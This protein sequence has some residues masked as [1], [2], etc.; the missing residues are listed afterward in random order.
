MRNGSHH[1]KIEFCLEITAFAPVV[2]L[3]VH[4]RLMGE[5][6]LLRCENPR[7]AGALTLSEWPNPVSAYGSNACAP[8]PVMTVG[9]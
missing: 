4:F 5:S 3:S 2:S 6:K 8:R 9:A 1:G 7:S